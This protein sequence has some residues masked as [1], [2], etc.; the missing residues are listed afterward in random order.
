MSEA[1]VLE[2]GQASDGVGGDL[3]G[4]T[5]AREA[6]LDDRGSVAVAVAVA[7]DAFPGTRGRVGHV[8]PAGAAAYGR[9]ESEQ[10]S[11]VG[12][13]VRFGSREEKE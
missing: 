7:G 10:G 2:I 11:S 8:P 12:R 13:Q 1:E 3:A 9:V 6:E 5:A 4:E